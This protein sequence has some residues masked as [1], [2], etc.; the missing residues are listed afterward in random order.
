M[1]KKFTKGFTLIELLV[2]I[3][4][5]GIL[6]SI[7]LVSLNSA[8]AKGRDANRVASLQQMARAVALIDKDPAQPLLTSGA[9]NCAASA[10]SDASLCAT[11]NLS[12]YKDPSTSSGTFCTTGSAATCQY[13]ISSASGGTTATSQNYEFCAYLETSGNIPNVPATGGVVSISSATS[14][15]SFGCL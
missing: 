5:I 12:A 3:A 13:S 1:H 7:V 6:A 9:V 14:S 4:I 15:V 10:H 2:V 8:R 11:P